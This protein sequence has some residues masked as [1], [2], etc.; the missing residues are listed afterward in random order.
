MGWN[1]LSIPKLQRCSRWSLGMDKLFHPTLYW[2]CDYLSMLGLRLNHVSKSGLRS[3]CKWKGCI[4]DR[5][6]ERR[7]SKLTI[8]FSK[9]ESELLGFFLTH[10]RRKRRS[11]YFRYHCSKPYGYELFNVISIMELLCRFRDTWYNRGLWWGVYIRLMV[12]I[13]TET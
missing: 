12:K 5:A 7:F 1:Y 13:T 11:S 9:T 3:Y 6:A 8:H 10:M 2:V 4:C